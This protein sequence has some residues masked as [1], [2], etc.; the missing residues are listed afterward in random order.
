MRKF[1]LLLNV[2]LWCTAAVT[3][4]TSD[5]NPRVGDAAAIRGGTLVIGRNSYP[6]SL[7]FPVS[8]D[9]AAQTVYK[10][11]VENL[12]TL[13]PQ[14]GEYV[15]LLAARWSISPDGKVFTF[16]L[17]KKAKFSDGTPVTSRDV[18]AFWEILHNP[19][20]IIGGVRA[21][22]S[23][24]TKLEVI[25]THTVKFYVQVA[26]FSNLGVLCD[27]FAVTSRAYYLAAG[28]DFNKSFS[29]ALFG[30]GPYLI[31]K[32]K[33]GKTITL[34]RN[35]R[36]WGAHLPQNIGRYNFDRL[37]LRTVTDATIRFEL[38]KKGKIDMFVF[39]D[40][41]RWQVD[42]GSAKFRHNWLVARRVDNQYPRKFRGIAINTRVKPF[43]DVRVRKALAH[44]YDRTRYITKLYYGIYAPLQSYWPG[45]IFSSPKNK[46]VQ[47]DLQK[48]R[49]LLREA[50]YTEVNDAGLAVKNGQPL[51]VDYLY[52]SR[53]QE[54][55]L[56]IW[57]EDLRKV[58]IDLKLELVTWPTLMKKLQN[59]EFVLMF[60][61]WGGSLN[62]DPY[63]MWHSQF[64]QQKHSSNLSGF[65]TQ[66][67]DRLLVKSGTL[68]DRHQRQQLFHLMDEIL[69]NNH[70]FILHWSKSFMQIGYWN[71]FR[72][73]PQGAPAQGD[74]DSVWQYAWYDA[75]KDKA[76]KAAM[77]ADKA[78]VRPA[79]VRGPHD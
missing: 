32:V 16:H 20:N 36:Y 75:V 65:T 43:D 8:G 38:F 9:L 40:A 41:K 67:L 68:F 34:V 72:L 71:K 13:N 24:F 19:N 64:L 10:L 56:T 21:E 50:G 11:V 7:N 60:I 18:Q 57:K 58:G 52:A 74:F 79:G 22:L 4:N 5:R 44:T 42:T 59:K 49:Q 66:E 77:R 35:K 46:I 54:R 61:G 26:R 33:K 31:E 53:Q 27:Y 55:Y 37:V 14:S 45:S 30:S 48:A 73:L 6:K 23:K 17:D 70:P 47:F 51:V 63:S 62:P 76:L 15:P 29:S 78:L 25:D 28:K 12:C 39:S 2:T 69:F 3:D 1:L